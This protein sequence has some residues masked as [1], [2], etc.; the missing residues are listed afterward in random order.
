MGDLNNLFKY[1]GHNVKVCYMAGGELKSVKGYML[2]VDKHY[3]LL[4]IDGDVLK[5]PIIMLREVKTVEVS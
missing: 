1:S 5:I 2:G 4:I 3:L